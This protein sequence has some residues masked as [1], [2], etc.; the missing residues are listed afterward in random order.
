[1]RLS[2]KNRIA[3][4]SVLGIA[5]ISLA[6]FIAI[7]FTVKN[8]VYYE[9]DT[10]LKFE[11]KKHVEEVESSQD[12]IYFINEYEWKEREHVEIEVYPLF[13]ELFNSGGESN[14][15][16]PNLRSKQLKVDATR[17]ET[18]INNKK[19]NEENIR[20]IQV[21]IEENN[22]LLGFIAI[23]VSLRDAELV[24]QT[25][26]NSLLLIYPILLII[27]FFTSRLISRVT[28]K[29]ITEIAKNV[30]EISTYNLNERLPENFNG[31]ELESLTKA[32][33]NFLNRI[34][35][36]IKREK[37][38]TADA[39]HQLRTP[40][41]VMKGNLQVL[42]RKQREP[43]NYIEEIKNSIKKIDEMTIAVEKLLILSRIQN[44]STQFDVQEFN[45][46]SIVEENLINYKNQ[47]L[48]KQLSLNVLQNKTYIL[49]SN[50]VYFSLILD[51]IISNAVKYAF[52]KTTIQI[53]ITEKKETIVLSFTN[54]G[55]KIK[56]EEME[57]IFN[58]FYRNKNHETTSKGYGLGLTIVTKAAALLQIKIEVESNK[59]TSFKLI[60]PKT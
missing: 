6:V 23:A 5:S 30:D 17:I 42:I 3:L 51:N 56:A 40:L 52:E 48:N 25:L 4:Y 58:P 1:M 18:F 44:E 59:Q 15:K 8:T 21:S 7:Y 11:A 53:Q 60:I 20:Q 12:S 50:K 57:S 55:P 39:S 41:A 22:K 19:L 9:I 46:F 32:V 49:K 37:Q 14:R 24:I 34:D 38:F 10:A 31:D 43:E 36:G 16:S 35:A 54:T 33:N 29:P 2:I 27:T 28:I 26:L 47:I 45:V 13:I